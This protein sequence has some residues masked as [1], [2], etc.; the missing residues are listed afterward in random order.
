MALTS[1]SYIIPKR[2]DLVPYFENVLAENIDLIL[3]EKSILLRARMSLL[4]GYYA[5]MLFKRF[6]DAF[7]KVIQFLIK[8]IELTGNEKVIAL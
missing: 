5:D 6:P 7:I 1:I 8:S 4:L 2:A 3:S